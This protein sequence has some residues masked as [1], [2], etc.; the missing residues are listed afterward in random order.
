MRIPDR[1]QLIGR[2][3]NIKYP[4]DFLNEEDLQG[5]ANYRNNTIELNADIIDE[6]KNLVFIHE[7]LHWMFTLTGYD[8]LSR[9][10]KMIDRLAEVL[11]QFIEQV[12]ED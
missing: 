4:T 3:I 11:Y 8:K 12:K 5:R 9:D 1:I 6:N 2:T 10:E 7:F